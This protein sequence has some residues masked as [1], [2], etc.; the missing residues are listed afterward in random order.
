MHC[1]VKGIITEAKWKQNNDT[2]CEAPS[3]SGFF[4]KV[5]EQLPQLLAGPEGSIPVVPG[6]G[7]GRRAALG[8]E[9]T[10]S[11]LPLT[12][13]EGAGQG[14]IHLLFL[15][16]FQNIFFVAARTLEK[17]YLSGS[18]RGRRWQMGKCEKGSLWISRYAA[19]IAT[20]ALIAPG[21]PGAHVR[22]GPEL[23]LALGIWN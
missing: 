4:L 11:P 12:L 22:Q 2:S 3:H 13:P 23:G 10:A 18:L 14:L 6:R 21:G 16:H 20:P 15:L 9:L 1:N 8:P 17:T 19:G 7:R 5:L